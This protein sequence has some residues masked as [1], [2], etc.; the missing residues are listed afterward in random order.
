MSRDYL[1]ELKDIIYS[2]KTDEEK[3]D[4][5]SEYHESDIADVVQELSKEDR[6]KIYELLGTENVSNIFPYFE[7]VDEVIEEIPLEDVADIIELMDSDDAIDVLEQLDEEDKEKI[8]SLM[9]DESVSDIEVIEGY[10]DDQI[11][12]KI[13]NNFIKITLTSSVPKAMKQVIELAAD[14]DNVS[15]IYVVDEDDKYYGLFELRDLI[16][17]RKNDDLNDIIKR[18]Y[19]TFLAT[20]TVEDTITK[21]QE[22][23]MD[24]YPILDNENHIIGIITSSDVLETVHEELSEDYNK[25]A[26]L[27]SDEEAD[28]SVLSSFKKRIPWLVVL[29]FLGMCVSLLTSRFENVVSNLPIIVFFQS[30]ILGMAGNSGTQSLAVTIRLLSDSEITGKEIRKT[31]FKEVRVGFLN[32]LLLSVISF[33]L[34]FFFLFISKSNIGGEPFSVIPGLKVSGIVSGSLLISMTISSVIGSLIPIIFKKIHIDPA[35]ASGPFITTIN[36]VLAVLIYYGLA[37]L[38]FLLI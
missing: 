21:L 8:V 19:P 33:L 34:V 10:E 13:T 22:Y 17:A 5:I 38:A 18:N 15:T 12:S 35:V 23:D 30:L 4:L 16:I 6:L 1:Q 36:D 27:S 3:R 24:S 31:I 20:N 28:A 32:G 11:G 7:D 25:L 14:N 9:E 2:N 26:G 29:L 37:S